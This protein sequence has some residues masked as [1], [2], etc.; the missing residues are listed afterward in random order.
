[1]EKS[2]HVNMS[3][4]TDNEKSTVWKIINQI[5]AIILFLFGLWLIGDAFGLLM[6]S[7]I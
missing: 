1:M 5:G 3:D 6:I 2:N 7:P 4:E